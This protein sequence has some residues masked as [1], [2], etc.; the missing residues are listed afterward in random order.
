MRSSALLFLSILC[1]VLQNLL[2]PTSSSIQN[3]EGSHQCNGPGPSPSPSPHG[4]S[5][6]LPPRHLTGLTFSL[7]RPQGS[8][9]ALPSVGSFYNSG[10]CLSLL[11]SLQTPPTTHGTPNSPQGPTG[12]FTKALPYPAPLTLPHLLLHSRSVLFLEHTISVTQPCLTLLQSHG[13]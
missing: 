8:G 6:R 4:L 10:Q 9:L 2:A 5:P 13:V 11:H 1:L 7:L 12:P 3:L